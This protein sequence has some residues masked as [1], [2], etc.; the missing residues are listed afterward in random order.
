MKSFKKLREDGA[1]AVTG[2]GNAISTGAIAGS[3][4]KG[5]EPGVN[6]KKKK[7][8]VMVPTFTRKAPKM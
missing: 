6:L 3:G 2:P 7:Q 8:V 1:A 5:G 4:G